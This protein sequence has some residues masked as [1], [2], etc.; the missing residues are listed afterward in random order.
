MAVPDGKAKPKFWP[1]GF[2]KVEVLVQPFDEFRFWNVEFCCP[3]MGQSGQ[4]GILPDVV[5]KAGGVGVSVLVGVGVGVK[6]FPVS[7]VIV[8]LVRYRGELPV[9]PGF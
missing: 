7:P 2:C 5:G 1:D 3:N 8:A 6:G 9:P 4:V